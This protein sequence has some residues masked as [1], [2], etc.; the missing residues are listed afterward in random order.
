MYEYIALS[1]HLQ[2][3]QIY[4]LLTGPLLTGF[5]G[6]RNEMT[7]AARGEECYERIAKVTGGRVWT[8]NVNLI[9]QTMNGMFVKH[10]KTEFN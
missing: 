9:S 4:F 5:K 10:R 1:K 6:C 2:M 7:A 3:F 8:G